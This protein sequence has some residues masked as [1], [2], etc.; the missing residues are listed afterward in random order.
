MT[1]A[2]WVNSQLRTI[3]QVD[4]N[5]LEDMRKYVGGSIC[6]AM[7]WKT[8]DVLYV[9]DEG[10]LK[11]QDNFFFIENCH[12]PLAG[13]G[14]IVGPEVETEN[15]WWTENNIITIE[16]LKVTWMTREDAW[17]WAVVNDMAYYPAY[18]LINLGDKE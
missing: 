18:R 10:L 6:F 12:Q 5:G 17:R 16:K 11:P 14:I 9:D 13:N 1:K 3:T 15:T 2:L 7:S 8:G 4:C